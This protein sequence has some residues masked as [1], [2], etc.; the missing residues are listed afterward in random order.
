MPIILTTYTAQ[1]RSFIGIRVEKTQTAF[2]G[3]GAATFAG[4]RLTFTAQ[5]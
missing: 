3:R 1:L 4:L 5:F 2:R